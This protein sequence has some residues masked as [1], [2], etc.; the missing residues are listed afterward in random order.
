M[1][2]TFNSLHKYLTYTCK[3]NRKADYYRY[4]A[5]FSLKR[6][7]EKYADLSLNAY[8][9]AYKH[10]L[11]TL[12]PTHPTRLGLALNFSV[13]Y[14]DVYRSPERA[15]HLAKH[16]FDEAIES[17]DQSSVAQ[18]LRDSLMILQLL[19]DDLI[20]WAAEMQTGATYSSSSHPLQAYRFYRVEVVE[21]AHSTEITH[22]TAF[23]RVSLYKPHGPGVETTR[24]PRAVV[25]VS[26]IHMYRNGVSVCLHEL[27]IRR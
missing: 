9:T 15:S 19:R 7:R 4:L 5:E 25:A 18:G 16:A 23:L 26:F 12:E 22:S 21:I 14:H 11:S 27:R 8:K 1:S 24:Q 3:R 17:L 6:D 13:Y 2:A 20:L 10:A